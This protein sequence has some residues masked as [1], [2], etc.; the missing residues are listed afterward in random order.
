MAIATLTEDEL[1][2]LK[3]SLKRCPE[4][5]FE[6]LVEYR[7]SGDP[8]QIPTI[9]NGIIEKFLEPEAKPLLHRNDDSIR[10]LEDLGIDSLTMMEIVIAV[11]EHLNI[12]FDNNE[13]RELVTIGDIRSYMDSKATGNPLPKRAES[14]GFEQIAERL[15]QQPPFLLLNRVSI[16]DGSATGEYRILGTESFLEG[17]FRDNPVFPASIMIEA[18]GQLGV[19]YLLSTRE[20]Q[21]MGAVS[22]ESIFFTSCDGIR[23]HRICRP[24]DTLKMEIKVKRIRHPLATFEG[25]I[26]VNGEKTV[27]A[28]SITLVFDVTSENPDPTLNGLNG[29]ASRA[30]LNGSHRH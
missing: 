26:T 6:A 9:V 25:S 8:A 17:H 2:R 29:E 27:F 15:P 1:R 23:C 11:E 21:L 4:G 20:E 13:L 5:T 10:L 16:L 30:L 24:G 3:E 14:L 12:S 18:L 28:D 7:K 19:L 22:P